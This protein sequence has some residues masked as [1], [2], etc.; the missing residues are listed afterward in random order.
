MTSPIGEKEKKMAGTKQESTGRAQTVLGEVDGDNL[1]VTLPHEHLL[2][3][4]AIAF[5]E[6]EKAGMKKKAYEPV[7]IEN[8]SWI[9]YN[10][11]SNLDNMRL[12]DEDLAVE[13][14][15]LFKKEGGGTIGSVVQRV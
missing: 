5:V 7:S 2:V 9:I 15:M 11:H 1:G 4:G 3:D 6:P 13:E 8:R 14:A 10:K 12:L